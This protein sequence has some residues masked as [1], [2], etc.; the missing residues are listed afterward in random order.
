MKSN[1]FELKI[2]GNLENL[3]QRNPVT[4]LRGRFTSISAGGFSFLSPQPVPRQV[5]FRV[6]L[7]LEDGNEALSAHAR[8]VNNVDLA[9]GQY[10]I[11]AAFVAM[12]D[13]ERDRIARFISKKQPKGLAAYG[14]GPV[15]G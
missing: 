1:Q 7:E 14:G 6:L 8:L 15:E 13:E 5:L 3:E 10:L 9:S 4:S 2:D 12:S 11:R